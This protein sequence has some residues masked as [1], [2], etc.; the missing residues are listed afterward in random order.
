[1]ENQRPNP[2]ELL[3]QVQAEEH[4]GLARPS[5]SVFR[6]VPPASAKPTPMLE[7]AQRQAAGNVDVVVGYIEPHARPETMAL[8]E[9]LESLPVR[10]IDY[11]GAR[12]IEFDL[13]AALAR[14]PKLVLVDELAHTNAHGSRHA[15][16]WQD[17]EELLEAGIDVYTTLNVQHIET[18]QRHGRSV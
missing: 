4:K 7:T 18:A 13:D 16:R 8:T 1:M 11:R 14:N 9:G 10:R 6:R 15:K 3:A 12:L 2:D 5:Q 17:V